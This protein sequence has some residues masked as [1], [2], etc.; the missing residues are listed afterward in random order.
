MVKPANNK[1]NTNKLMITGS[2]NENRMFKNKNNNK[3]QNTRQ[4][5]QQEQEKTIITTAMTTMMKRKDK[6]DKEEGKDDEQGKRD[7]DNNNLEEDDDME[8]WREVDEDDGVFWGRSSSI[9]SSF[10]RIGKGY[11]SKGQVQN[12]RV[13]WRRLSTTSEMESTNTTG[14]GAGGGGGTGGGGGAGLSNT[15][16][17]KNLFHTST[18]YHKEEPWQ[19]R[20]SYYDEENWEQ[21]IREIRNFSTGILWLLV[22]RGIIFRCLSRFNPGRQRQNGRRGGSSSG[23]NSVSTRGGRGGGQRR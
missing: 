8:V 21:T 14:G 15:K 18:L 19:H 4:E 9:R 17:F 22:M 20:D 7:D 1:D 3:N 10:F 13:R 23:G 11:Y 2:N 16:K 6:D 5:R 12:V